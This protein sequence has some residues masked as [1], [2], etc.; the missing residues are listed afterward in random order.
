MEKRSYNVACEQ[1]E[2]KR[3]RALIT[4][5][6]LSYYRHCTESGVPP[7]EDPELYETG[8]LEDMLEKNHEGHIPAP[9]VTCIPG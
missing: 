4:R 6:A 5:D 8:Q 3:K 1:E 7:D 2:V 9:M